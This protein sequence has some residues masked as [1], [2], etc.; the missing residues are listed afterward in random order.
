MLI[1]TICFYMVYG[2]VLGTGRRHL[3]CSL[4]QGRA[5]KCADQ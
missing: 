4:A 1:G 5:A 3:A 2:V